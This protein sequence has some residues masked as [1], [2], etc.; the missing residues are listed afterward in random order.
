MITCDIMGG[1]GNQLFQIFATISYAMDNNIQFYFPNLLNIGNRN[2]YF[3][4]LLNS[5]ETKNNLLEINKYKKIKLR[6]YKY[7]EPNY[8]YN[9]IPFY[10]TINIFGYFQ[11]EKYFINNYTKIIDYLQ[12]DNKINEQLQKNIIIQNTITISLHIRYSDYQTANNIKIFYLLTKE[13]YKR[14]LEYII[15]SNQ[16][17]NYTIY[18]FCPKED[19][20][21][22]NDIISI[23]ESSFKNLTFIKI[24]ENISEYEQLLLMSL[25][26]HNI[27]A[28][29][30]FSWW[31]A[32]LNKNPNKIICYPE[33]WY[34]TLSINDLIPETKNY[35]KIP[36]D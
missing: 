1:L 5:L 13:Y 30:T 35:I 34:K 27:I 31:A 4:T 25:T 22:A 2:T 15:N 14:S 29:S 28:N 11:S 19:N 26:N 21:I 6:H 17:E 12:L 9:K 36:I 32:Y 18:Y 16:N 23:L 7:K 24:N 3:K 20:S 33:K 8:T 10:K